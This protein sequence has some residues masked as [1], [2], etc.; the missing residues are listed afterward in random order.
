MNKN[1]LGLSIA[2]GAMT[3]TL[4]LVPI[5][6]TAF[7]FTG[8]EVRL[9]DAGM[10]AITGLHPSTNTTPSQPASQAPAQQAPAS[11]TPSTPATPAPSYSA[12]AAQTPAVPAYTAPTTTT[13]N[14]STAAVTTAP[15]QTTDTTDSATPAEASSEAPKLADDVANV[16]NQT[17]EQIQKSEDQARDDLVAAIK[18]L[19]AKSA[20][21]KAKLAAN[22][23]IAKVVTQVTTNTKASVSALSDSVATP[24]QKAIA[25]VQLNSA[26]KLATV[27]YTA[28]SVSSDNHNQAFQVITDATN[29]S[30]SNISSI[31]ADQIKDGKS[32]EYTQFATSLKTAIDVIALQGSDKTSKA[33]VKAL[34]QTAAQIIAKAKSID[35][36]QALA[37]IKAEE[38]A[39]AKAAAADQP[40]K[41]TVAKAKAVAPTNHVGVIATIAGLVLVAIGSFVYMRRRQH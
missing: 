35:K 22:Q 18:A 20:S 26:T 31:N 6:N 13:N 10:E 15:A 8:T 1:K 5:N 40:A 7:A 36:A 19:L 4:G 3:L 21:A 12:P 14:G 32:S 41:K 29:A 34:K 11:Q 17:P 23:S 39:L 37:I 33:Q 24:E 9:D 38:K 30:L 28:K 16:V 25:T 27:V 2:T